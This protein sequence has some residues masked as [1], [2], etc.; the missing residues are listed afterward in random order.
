MAP[1]RTRFTKPALIHTK[2]RESCHRDSTVVTATG[3]FA[4]LERYWS[5]LAAPGSMQAL[6][7]LRHW[8]DEC[9]HTHQDCDQGAPKPLPKRILNIGDTRVYLQESI[10]GRYR[11]ACLSHCWGPKGPSLRLTTESSGQLFAGV[12]IQDLPKVFSHAIQLCRKLAIQY[13]WID[14][15]CRSSSQRAVFHTID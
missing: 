8:I 2:D 12:L 1:T 7:L 13:L 14:A 3:S 9:V 10:A 15:L 11:Y 5:P 6:D 4:K